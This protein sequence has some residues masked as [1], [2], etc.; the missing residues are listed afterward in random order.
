MSWLR[1]PAPIALFCAATHLGSRAHAAPTPVTPAIPTTISVPVGSASPTAGSATPATAPSTS[2][3]I[4]IVPQAVAAAVKGVVTL[5]VRE[6]KKAP[7]FRGGRFEWEPVEGS[8][9]GSGVVLSSDGLI[10]TNAHVVSGSSEVRIRF[11][12]GEEVEGRVLAVDEASDLALVRAARGSFRA[13]EFAEGALPESGTP[14]FV[15]GDRA[16]AGPEVAWGTIGSHRKVRAGARPLEFWCEVKASV[17]PGD[18][19]GALLNRSGRLIGIPSLMI[20]YNPGAS[21]VSAGAVGL[22]IPAAHVHRVVARMLRNPAVAWAFLGAL[23][24]DPLLAASE[25]RNFEDSQGARVRRVFPG[26]P[27][28]RAGLRPGDR[29]TAIGNRPARDDFDALDAVLDLSPGGSVRI[30]VSRG[31]ERIELTATVGTRPP[32]PR[33]DPLDDFTLHTGLRL[34]PRADAEAGLTVLASAGMS[35]RLM[36]ELLPLEADLFA[37]SPILGS[38]LP[39][40]DALAGG[41]KRPSPTSAE[42]LASLLPRCFVGEEFVALAHWTTGDMRTI[43]RA[44]VHRKVYPVVL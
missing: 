1:R 3:A 39:G 24:D 27:A 36:S 33:P 43:D 4:D 9:V 15:V 38:L 32:D 16:D 30:V 2:P 12:P 11:A 6:I 20:Q 22:F 42:D 29:I 44:H 10:V 37:S 35:P 18:S 40:Q 31:A 7:V 34:V 8:G 13:I 21:A 19:G 26:S 25:G 41:S 23:L 28:E 17:G 5:R 14:A